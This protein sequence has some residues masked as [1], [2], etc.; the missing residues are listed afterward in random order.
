MLK[1]ESKKYELFSYLY[2]ICPDFVSVDGTFYM[3]AFQ[4]NGA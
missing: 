3:E 1:A 4:K 2:G